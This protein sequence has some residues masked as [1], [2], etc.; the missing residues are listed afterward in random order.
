MQNAQNDLSHLYASPDTLL[1]LLICLH[2]IYDSVENK[3]TTLVRIVTKKKKNSK[4]ALNED[5]RSLHEICAFDQ[6]RLGKIYFDCIT[7]FFLFSGSL[8]QTG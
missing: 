6:M 4:Y 5:L 7:C 8:L 3:F 1:A 2:V